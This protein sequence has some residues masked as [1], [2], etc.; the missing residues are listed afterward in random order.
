MVCIH[1]ENQYQVSFCPS[2]PREIS[3]LPELALGHLQYGLTH[4]PPD[5]VPRVGRTWETLVAC[6]PK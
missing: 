2:A 3:V 1:T 4:S 5:A 6:S